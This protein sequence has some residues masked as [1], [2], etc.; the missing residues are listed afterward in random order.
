MSPDDSVL[1]SAG[2]QS[3][4]GRTYDD[5]RVR[6]APGSCR[7]L[8]LGSTAPL[9][10]ALSKLDR[11]RVRVDDHVA[12]SLELFVPPH[13]RPREG[14]RP[15]DDLPGSL[16]AEVLEDGAGPG[17]WLS[18]RGVQNVSSSITSVPLPS[19]NVM[20]ATKRRGSGID[21]L[22][23]D[24]LVCHGR[25]PKAP[26]VSHSTGNRRITR[27][28]WLEPRC[29]LEL[30]VEQSIEVDRGLRQRR[31]S[32]RNQRGSSHGDQCKN[33]PHPFP[34]SLLTAKRHRANGMSLFMRDLLSNCDSNGR[35]G[36]RR[37]EIATEQQ[38]LPGSARSH[39]TAIP[40]LFVLQRPTRQRIRHGRA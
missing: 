36:R 33:P 18:C 30:L 6:R 7:N 11:P 10:L 13:R 4:S 17:G 20:V 29:S 9:I 37:R 31:R 22:A 23:A 5:D 24:E 2:T 39:L 34:S 15:A 32:E 1:R 26:D 19:R 21:R 8:S 38:R 28:A 14:N 35:G 27:R 40:P 16:D 3:S 12:G 25:L